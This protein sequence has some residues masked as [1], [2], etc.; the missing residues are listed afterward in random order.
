MRMNKQL[1][2]LTSITYAYKEIDYLAKQG[3][4]AY[5]E[6]TQEE[7]KKK[8][9]SYSLAIHGDAQEVAAVL[10]EAGIKVLGVIQ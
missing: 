2:M 4:C 10:T 8:G 6:R 9:C 5:I 7:L 1:I 3:I